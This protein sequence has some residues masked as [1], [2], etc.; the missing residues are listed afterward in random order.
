V[1]YFCVEESL[2]DGP[3]KIGHV[4]EPVDSKRWRRALIKRLRILQIGNPRGMA[5]VAVMDG[6]QPEESA[7]HRR[8]AAQHLLGEWF[9]R[10]P[11]LSTLMEQHACAPVR[12]MGAMLKNPTPPSTLGS[13]L[14]TPRAAG[15]LSGYAGALKEKRPGRGRVLVEPSGHA[16]RFAVRA[17]CPSGT[18]TLQRG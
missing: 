8:F 3:V 16:A 4:K 11:D 18:A 10:S 1:I 17:C 14:V 5:V 9:A 6:G 12:S 2:A 7:L 13:D 15:S